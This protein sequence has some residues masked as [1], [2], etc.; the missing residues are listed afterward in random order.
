MPQG[1]PTTFIAAPAAG[2]MRTDSP[3]SRYWG[4]ILVPIS[5]LVAT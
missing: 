2:G 4:P 5:E 1:S 3:A